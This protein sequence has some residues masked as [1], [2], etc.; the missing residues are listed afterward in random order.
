M[1][2]VELTPVFAAHRVQGLRRRPRRSRASGCRA[3]PSDF[4]RN[5][6]DALTD[7]AKQLGAKGLVWMRVGDERRARQPGR[8]VPLR[9]RA[10]RRCVAALGAEA[11]DLLLLVADE[12]HA[13]CEVLGTLRNDLGRPPVHEGPYRYVWVVDFPMFVGADRGRHPEAGPPPL[14]PAPPRRPRQ[15]RVRPDVGAVARPTTSCSTAGSSARARSGSTS[16]T[17]SSASSTCSA[18]ARRRRRQRFGFFLTPFRYG[19]PPHGGFAFGIDR[20]VADPRRRG[21]HPR[22]HRLPEAAVRRRPDDRRPHARRRR[23]ARRPR[24]EGPS[25]T[26]RVRTRSVRVHVRIS[27]DGAHRSR[28]LGR[29]GAANRLL[30]DASDLGRSADDVVPGEPKDRPTQRDQAVLARAVALEGLRGAVRSVA[31]PPRSRSSEH[32][33]GGID[34]ERR[35]VPLSHTSC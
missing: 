16:P 32:R 9:R 20:L 27:L 14:H 15:A 11:G 5:K 7:R 33:V 6:L 25:P 24:P 28:V 3:A 26:P 30:D 18:S 35:S 13:T 4:G 21:E 10:G 12:W 29:G 1:E 22:G 34:S 19:A 8:Q 23:A 2:L 17:C 31:R